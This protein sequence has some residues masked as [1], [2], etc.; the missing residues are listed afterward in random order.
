MVKD[1]VAIEWRNALQRPVDHVAKVRDIGHELPRANLLDIDMA[2]RAADLRDMSHKRAS[3]AAR[4][5]AKRN[6]ATVEL[7]KA[8]VAHSNPTRAYVPPRGT[9]PLKD[10]RSFDTPR[11]PRVSGNV[12]R[13]NC[14]AGPRRPG[15]IGGGLTCTCK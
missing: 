15:G 9:T 1:M 12:H 8:R 10:G 6:A 4:R 14:N 7:L 2:V 3:G 11:A 5:A 13:P